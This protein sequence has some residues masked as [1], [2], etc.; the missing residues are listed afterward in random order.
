MQVQCAKC[1]KPLTLT[2]IIESRDGHLSHIDLQATSSP[3][4]G[5][6]STGLPLLL[7]SRCRPMPGL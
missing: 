3:D 2:D 7:R 6:E 5:R 4:T 1:S